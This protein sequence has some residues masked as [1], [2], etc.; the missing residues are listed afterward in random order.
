MKCFEMYFCWSTHSLAYKSITT[1]PGRKVELHLR[2]QEEA[3]GRYIDIEKDGRTG[4]YS[5]LDNNLTK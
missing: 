4:I 1:V 5:I 2:A 3:K